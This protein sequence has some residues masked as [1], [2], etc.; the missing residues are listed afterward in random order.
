M[1][2]SVVIVGVVFGLLMTITTL[3]AVSTSF[4]LYEWRRQ[5]LED[6]LVVVPEDLS[7]RL[8]GI[9][10]SIC[11]LSERLDRHSTSQQASV[12]LERITEFGE[13]QLT[14]RRALD[15]R[16]A[17]VRRL[18]EGYDRRLFNQF[19][20]R[21]IR[22]DKELRDELSGD[23]RSWKGIDQIA[24]LLVDALDECGV[25]R[26]EPEIGEPYREAIGVED[27]PVIIHTNEEAKRGTIASVI[28]GGY[29]VRQDDGQVETILPARVS[30]YERK[31]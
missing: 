3:V 20:R 28:E 16:D 1:E 10:D 26:F 13:A 8:D 30:V 9:A 4:Y 15:D 25:E 23:D 24:D 31:E 12:V 7:N 29:I 21:F 2:S 22:I 19:L 17:E 11:V 14:F 5:L 18:R 6:P 27:H